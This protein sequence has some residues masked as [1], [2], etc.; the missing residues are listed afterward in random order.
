MCAYGSRSNIIMRPIKCLYLIKAGA[1]NHRPKIHVHMLFPI[2]DLNVWFIHRAQNEHPQVQTQAIK[3]IY[4][5]T[6]TH[7]HSYIESMHF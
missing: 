2:T 4:T 3:Y 6:Y 1:K 7:T 5:H